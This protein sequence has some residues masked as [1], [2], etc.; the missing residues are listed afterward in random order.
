MA[1]VQMKTYDSARFSPMMNS[2][3]ANCPP[4]WNLNNPEQDIT[5][6]EIPS[7]FVHLPLY[8]IS[9]I[10]FAP[11]SSILCL[12][13]GIVFSLFKPQDHKQLDK[14]MI[15]PGYKTLFYWWPR[16]LRRMIYN[17]YEQVGTEGLKHH[18]NVIVLP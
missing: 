3:I 6:V 8:D 17:Y 11:I 1:A 15:S 13:V 14:R 4:S 5:R 9:Y 16:R 18:Q 7:G 12:L 10:W 2:S